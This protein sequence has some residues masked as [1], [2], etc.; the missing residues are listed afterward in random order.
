M[1]KSILL[2]LFA[3]GCASSSAPTASPPPEPPR[4]ARA[5]TARVAECPQ[6]CKSYAHYK[7]GA[8]LECAEM[9]GCGA[10]PTNEETAEYG[11]ELRDRLVAECGSGC[12]EAIA[13]AK[14][15]SR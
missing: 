4:V 2:C 1:M 13:D 12:P 5:G 8:L 14:A 3:V 7:Q 15:K 9:G 6:L 11:R 10:R